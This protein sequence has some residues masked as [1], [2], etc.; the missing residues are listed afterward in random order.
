LHFFFF[1]LKVCIIIEKKES[2]AR[3]TGDEAKRGMLERIIDVHM[4]VGHRFEWTKKAQAVWLDTGPYVPRLF[5]KEERQLA[6]GYGDIIKEEAWAGILIPEYSPGSAGVMPFERAEEISRLH[7]ELAPIANLNPNFHD[8]LMASFEKQR[9]QGAKALKIHPIHGSFFAND[10]RL[11]PVYDRCQREGLAVMFHAG[12]SLFPGCKMRYAD[13]YAF[14]DVISDFPDLK[15]VLCHG[16]RPFWFNIAEFLAKRFE[17]VYIDVSGLPPA[18]L[19]QYFPA[20]PKRPRKFLF[21]SDFPG[22]PG[23]KKNYDALARLL[24]DDEALHRIRFQNAYDLFGF[25]KEGIFEVRDEKEIFRVVNDAAERYRGVIPGDRWAEPYMPLEEV[26]SEMKRMRFYGFRREMELLG[27]MGKER[28]ADATLIRHAYVDTRSQ[29]KGIGSKL[30]RFIEKQV[31][32]EWLFVGTWEAA[33]W[34]AAFYRKHGYEHMDNK[35]D[36]L[37]RYW[38]IPDRQIETSAVLGKRMR[39]V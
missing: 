11:Y 34:A 26:R 7:P 8:D 10:P 25:W 2:N 31:D 30:L 5:D 1:K 4:H 18:K 39:T 29:G 24:K 9:A 23:I 28:S 27:V 3:R 6:Q 14:D 37:R 12:T 19:L 36:L 16:G 20:M 35:D 38:D 21:G 32:T 22:V 15:V 13:P 33:T 17:N